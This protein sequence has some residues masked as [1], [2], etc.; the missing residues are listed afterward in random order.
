MLEWLFNII[1]LQT[2]GNNSFQL[3]ALTL[4]AL[5]VTFIIYLIL[6]WYLFLNLKSG[7]L[8]F[9]KYALREGERHIA[10]YTGSCF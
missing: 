4:L 8:D 7:L 3:N 5:A 1:N 6:H 10:V 9:Y 2:G